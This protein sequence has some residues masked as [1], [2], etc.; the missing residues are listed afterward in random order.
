[1]IL[2]PFR[3]FR[4]VLSFDLLF[5]SLCSGISFVVEVIVIGGDLLD[6][7]GA[8]CSGSLL[9]HISISEGREEVASSHFFWRQQTLGVF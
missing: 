1:M 2:F 4:I 6:F 7:L 8:S 3:V 9:A 5:K